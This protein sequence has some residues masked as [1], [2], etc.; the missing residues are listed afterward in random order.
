VKQDDKEGLEVAIQCIGEAFGVDSSDKDQSE[1]L[2]IKP[3]TLESVFNLFLK[4]RDKV[5]SSSATPK[6][7]SPT[8]EDKGKADKLKQKGNALMSG[9]DFTAA[10]DSYTQAIELDSTNPVYYSNRAAAHSSKGDHL[11]A[12]G[13]AE[14]AIEVDPTY[15]KAYHRLGHA[16][17]SLGDYNE[18]ATS[19]QRGL[20]VEPGNASLTSALTNAETRAKESEPLSDVPSTRSP[21]PGAGPGGMDFSGMADM[22]QGMGGGGPGGGGEGGIGGMLN[23][24]MMMQMAQQMMANGGLER[25]MQNP[26]VASMMNR[27]QSG[28]GMPSMAELMSDP[29][30]RDLA[31]QFGAAGA[32]GGR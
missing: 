22:L 5:A 24:P 12:V 1:R 19:F 17:Y 6:S 29:S 8:V 32:A 23:N 28:G 27:V 9:K 26:S 31:S 7:A 13:D 21:Q 3:A 11:L 30:L 25:L 15:V 18:A 4:T 10:I 14:K 2:S 20:D 16:H